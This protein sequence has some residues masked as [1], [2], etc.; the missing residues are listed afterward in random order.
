MK[1]DFLILNKKKYKMYAIGIQEDCIIIGE[2][3]SDWV[4]PNIKFDIV[5]YKYKM[6]S[7][8]ES[9]SIQYES[10]EVIRSS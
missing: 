5:Y 2:G 6:Q 1:I 7:N 8:V 10:L 4:D 9:G 3:H